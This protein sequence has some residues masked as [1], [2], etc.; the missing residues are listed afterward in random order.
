MGL[1]ITDI[2]M[3]EMNGFEI[4][5]QLHSDSHN[6]SRLFRYPAVDSHLKIS[7]PRI[8]MTPG[9][10]RFSEKPFT[11]EQL[12]EVVVDLIAQ[13]LLVSGTIIHHGSV[14]VSVQML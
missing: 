4:I 6:I 8:A 11:F 7:Q 10:N 12:L 9:V 2:E 5:T 3:L 1:V 14:G 13:F